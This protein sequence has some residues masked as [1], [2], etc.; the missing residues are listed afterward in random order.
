MDNQE[1]IL[2][3]G[4]A[5]TI[6]TPPLGLK[7]PGQYAIRPAQGITRDLKARAIAFQSGDQKAILMLCDALY[8]H[9]K[10]INQIREKIAA[11]C[12]MP[13][14]SIHIACNH[15]HTATAVFDLDEAKDE[16]EKIYAARQH[17]QL[18]DLAQFAFEDLHP[19]TGMKKAR[20]EVKNVAFLRRYRMNTGECCTNP[21]NREP[22]ILHPLGEADES[23][24][25]VRVLR[26][27]AKEIVLLFLFLLRKN[28]T[29]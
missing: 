6:I 10:G 25:M 22:D 21:V 9:G 13:E 5:E 17:Q 19:V 2:S 1:K 20:G 24:Q 27:G 12:E 16:L 8:I 23:L 26:E 3:A 29:G 11:R 15:S 4:Y 7:M 18:T 28:I 14:E